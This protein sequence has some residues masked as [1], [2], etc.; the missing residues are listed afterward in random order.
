MALA[1]TAA[2]PRSKAESGESE[3]ESAKF[4]KFVKPRSG[5]QEDGEGEKAK[6]PPP[7]A[8]LGGRSCSVVGGRWPAAGGWWLH[9]PAG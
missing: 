6:T 7:P 5:K 8:A 4:V 3:S 9:C 1:A 2:G